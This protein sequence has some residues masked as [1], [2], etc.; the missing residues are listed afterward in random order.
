MS[1]STAKAKQAGKTNTIAGSLVRCEVN[2]EKGEWV[3]P[4]SCAV[5]RIDSEA[6]FPTIVFEI[7]T[8]HGGPY[9]WSWDMTWVVKA[10]PQNRNKPRFNPK[11]PKTF[12]AKGKFCSPSKKWI[13]D[14]NGLV[15]VR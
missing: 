4:E 10:C 12:T 5:Y 9:E 2:Q 14:L 11:A 15:I 8:D 3:S 6:K 13:A 7:K 1:E